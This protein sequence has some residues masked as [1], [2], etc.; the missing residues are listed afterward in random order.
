MQCPVC[1]SQNH[2]SL[3]VVTDVLYNVAKGEFVVRRCRKC[4]A[5]FIVPFPTQAETEGFYPKHYYSYDTGESDGFFEN[6]KK[7]IIHGKMSGTKDLSIADRFLVLLFQ[8]KFAGIPLYRKRGGK[9]LDVGCGS[10]KNLKTL[11][12]YGWDTYGI[13]LD[14]HAVQHAQ[15]QGLR[16]QRSSLEEVSYAEKFD[17]VRVWHVF[18]HLTDP[19][20]AIRKLKDLLAPDGEILMAV[21]NTQSWARMLFGRYW[22]SLDAPRHVINYSPQTLY[23]L[24]QRHGLKIEE[25]RY[26]SC[27][28]FVGSISNFLRN[29][30]HYRG[31]LINNLLL[32]FLLS[33]IDFLSDIFRR[34]DTIYLKIRNK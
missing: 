8:N 6:I 27:G 15:G 33:P 21:P 19:H 24:M 14:E 2:R 13:E 20:K 34:G 31:N 26:A 28:S 9:F 16:V 17:C 18:E 5:F 23:L 12:A 4:E 1:R 3:F 25:I 29:H 7:K 32:I 10:G 22:Y 30:F 11:S